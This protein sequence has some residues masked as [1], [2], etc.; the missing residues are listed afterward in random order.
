[1]ETQRNE[2]NEK[3]FAAGI[4]LVYVCVLNLQQQMHGTK[5]KTHTNLDEKEEEKNAIVKRMSLT[6]GKMW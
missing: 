1:M 3:K 5:K 4:S 2:I 6:K